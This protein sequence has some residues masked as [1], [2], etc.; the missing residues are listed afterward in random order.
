MPHQH[1]YERTL[2]CIFLQALQK[3]KDKSKRESFKPFDRSFLL[4]RQ[5]TGEDIFRGAYKNHRVP[6]GGRE[7]EEILTLWR[8]D[9]DLKGRTSFVVHLRDCQVKTIFLN[10]SNYKFPNLKIS[11]VVEMLKKSFG[12]AIL[13]S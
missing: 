7:D 4:K 2:I 1:L 10:P 9:G 5:P 8:E 13:K 11:V 12:Y 3:L 6:V